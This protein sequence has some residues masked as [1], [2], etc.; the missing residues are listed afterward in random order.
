M[1]IDVTILAKEGDRSRLGAR[2]DTA[3]AG[4]HPDGSDDGDVS[5]ANFACFRTIK[6]S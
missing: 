3:A 1:G 2:I 6:T 4:P 5:I